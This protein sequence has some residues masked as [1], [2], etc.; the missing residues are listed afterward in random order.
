MNDFSVFTFQAAA[1]LG[2][3]FLLSQLL[4]ARLFARQAM[5]LR[6][7]LI[8][9]LSLCLLLRVEHLALAALAA[10]L[11]IGS[12]FVLRFQGRHLFNPTALA[13]G[14]TVVLFDG[15]WVS[16][17][18]WG[19]TAFVGLAVAGLGLAV[20][21]RAR[22]LDVMLCF[23]SAWAA[24]LVLRAAFYGDPLSIP[25]HQLG[26]G[27]VLLFAF[28]MITDPRTTPDTRPARALFAVA[29][30]A[31][32]GLIAFGMHRADALILALAACGPL[33]PLLERLFPRHR[34]PGGAAAPGHPR[35]RSS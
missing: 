28:F 1:A 19:H 4:G 6:S 22:R 17:G 24:A 5:D 8:S 34:L 31:T 7:P 16:T 26:N 35:R 15:A 20:L 21:T 12:K 2:S 32:A 25:L 9:A 13:I 33:V 11:A 10:V 29:V 27:A 18:Q 14:V 3:G 30:A 23:L